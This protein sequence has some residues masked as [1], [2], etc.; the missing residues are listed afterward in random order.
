MS[1]SGNSEF[2]ESNG[3]MSESCWVFLTV[4]SPPS[5]TVCGFS[6]EVSVRS[7]LSTSEENFPTGNTQN[8][9]HASCAARAGSVQ[10][11]HLKR[12]FSRRT[13]Q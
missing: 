12:L 1:I 3:S 2:G 9:N 8:V 10:R 11:G 5:P 4:L 13:Q 6:R 7:M